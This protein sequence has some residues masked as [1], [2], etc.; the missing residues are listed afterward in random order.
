MKVFFWGLIYILI[1][2][3]T[4]SQSHN[5]LVI[6]N[7]QWKVLYDDDA[8]PWP[9]YMNGWLLRGDT[10]IDGFQYKKLYSRT[11]E[12]PSSNLIVSQE[13]YGF[14]REDTINKIVYALGD[15]Y[16]GCY[17]SISQEFLLFDFS[18]EIGDT[19]H[20]CSQNEDVGPCIVM[21]TGIINIYGANRI[22]FNYDCGTCDFIEGIGHFQGLI[23]SPVFNISGGLTTSLYDYCVGTDDEC[24]VL[25]VYL[26]EPS[27]QYQ[28]KVYPNPSKGDFQILSKFQ[29]IDKLKY[30]LTDIYGKK[31]IYKIN[32]I[33][34]HEIELHLFNPGIYI[35]TV[36]QQV[37]LPSSYKIININF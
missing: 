5:K 30:S 19:S 26:N 25:Y 31:V 32:Y 17:D 21:D 13:M 14:L 2:I 24:N 34:G 15:Q 4:F 12:S 29:D 23:E 3:N 18:Y 16:M 20:L 27:N 8:T 37:Q 35:L 9:D 10:I 7:A 1:S 22:I 33:L 6:Q 36:Y 28:I 11:F